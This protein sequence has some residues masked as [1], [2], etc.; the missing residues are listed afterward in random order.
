[1]RWRV[2]GVYLAYHDTVLRKSVRAT[3]TK[4]PQLPGADAFLAWLYNRCRCSRLLTSK[5]EATERKVDLS[6]DDPDIVHAMLHYLYNFDYNDENVDEHGS[7][8]CMPF[9]IRVFALAHKYDVEPLK[10]FA[11]KRFSQLAEQ[12][13]RGSG[14][15]R[16]VRLLYE[17]IADSGSHEKKLYEI[18]VEYVREYYELLKDEDP[19]FEGALDEVAGFGAH[20]AAALMTKGGRKNRDI[21]K[22]RCD[23]CNVDVEM[24]IP[25]NWTVMYCPS[26]GSYDQ[27]SNW[28]NRV[29][30]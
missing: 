7:I 10:G 26:C 17:G 30:Q 21:Q 11:R 27:A 4:F 14:F 9:N 5:Q 8:S 15:S 20:V 12:E 29:V 16:A 18:V 23:N 28:K 2:Q 1:M 22:Y 6:V 24:K 25:K 19:G 13:P 3:P